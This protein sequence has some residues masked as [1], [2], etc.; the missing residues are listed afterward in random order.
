MI[1][2]L[3][4]AARETGAVNVVVGHTLPGTIR[5]GD[6]LAHFTYHTVGHWRLAEPRIEAILASPAV[7]H[8]NGAE[9]QPGDSGYAAPRAAG[10][11]YRTLLLRVQPDT[12]ERIVR[13]FETDLRRMPKFVNTIRAW[14]LSR[15]DR[16]VGT[17]RWTHVYE[18]EFT[19]AA[20]LLGPYLFHPVHWAVV[21]GW[22]DPE[23]P[24]CI[25]R[26]RVCHSFCDLDGRVLP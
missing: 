15:V 21:D 26:D 19:D 7:A 1:E 14:Q 16:A 17:S 20:G 18:Q 3:R 4:G 13:Q 8:V 2:R 5:G 24:Q 23:R 11:V 25:I 6:V 22:F 12:A 9:Y 10:T